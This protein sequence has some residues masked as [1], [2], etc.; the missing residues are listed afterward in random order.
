MGKVDLS[1]SY[2]SNL[3]NITDLYFVAKSK[4]NLL[5]IIFLQ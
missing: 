5:E 2:F 4:E 1:I 3:L